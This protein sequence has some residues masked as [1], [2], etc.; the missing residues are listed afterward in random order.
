MH[1]RAPSSRLTWSRPG[2]AFALFLRGRTLRTAGPTAALV[3]T[4]LSLVNQGTVIDSGHAT[5]AT[6]VRVVVS[7]VV[8][9]TVTS[10][11]W[12]AARH[13]RQVSAPD[14]TPGQTQPPMSSHKDTTSEVPI[15]SHRSRSR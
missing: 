12:I 14:T 13:E 6:W 15:V 9:F 10:F 5:G 7:Y 8:P 1:Q 4:V 11:G 2:D 3:G